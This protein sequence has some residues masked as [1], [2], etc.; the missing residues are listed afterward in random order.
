M[1]ITKRLVVPAVLGLALASAASAA[2]W[3]A[4]AA[5]RDAAEVVK[6]VIPSV[7]RVETQNHVRRVATGIVIDKDGYILTTAL[8]SPRNEKMSV[9]TSDGRKLEAEFIGFDVET[10]VALVRAKDRGLPAIAAG[11]P[12]ELAPGS[13]V[14]VVGFSPENTPAVAQ[15]IVSSI[16]ADKLRLNVWVTP[17]SSGGPVVNEKGQ[18]VGLLRGI[19][20]EERPIVFNFRDREQ[21][22]L[23]YVFSQAEAPSSGMALAVPVSL[24][25]DIAGQLRE[26]KTVER[27]WL[28]VGIALNEKGQVVISEV[29]EK[30]P[31][32]LAK[33]QE[34]DVILSLDGKDIN[35]P[36]T[37][38]AEVRGR[39]PGRE[40][41]VKLERDGKPLEVKVR[42]GQYPE[43]EARR[44][45]EARFPR[46]FPPEVF[47][48]A[49][50]EQKRITAPRT[51]FLAMGRSRYIGVYCDEL[52]PELAAHF[53]VKEGRALIV[54]RLTEKGPAEKAGIKVGDVI[55]RVDGRKVESV[56]D[57]ID[58]VQGRKKGE[59]VKVELLREKKAL[60]VEVEIGEQE[61]GGFFN[62]EGL[63]N[64]LETFRDYAGR[65]E[66]EAKKWQD[67]YSGSLREYMKQMSEELVKKT[68]EAEKQV[69]KTVVKIA[70]TRKV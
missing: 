62:E 51:P 20:T 8:I 13:W 25:M 60:T 45:L 66:Q 65:M 7:V 53:G 4:V 22:G 1:N 44:E 57:L 19:Y 67:E 54:S 38:A 11:K 33:L 3:P 55:Y 69:K 46:I 64:Y 6:K 10:Q 50:P 24:V 35:S 34:G 49:G 43:E 41:A 37:L 52:T 17:G 23:G 63:R 9:T 14:A 29:D 27:G 56:N 42:L 32:E 2:A 30:S 59:K 28:G 26:K 21:T 47:L 18:M 39:K 15:G 48:R 5:D 68:Q 58:V 70:G 31:A 12:E 40:V 61:L 36:D 16:A